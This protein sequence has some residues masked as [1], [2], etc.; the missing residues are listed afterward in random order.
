MQLQTAP[1]A[2][3]IYQYDYEAAHGV[4]AKQVCVQQ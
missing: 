1:V 3:S 2:T 4:V